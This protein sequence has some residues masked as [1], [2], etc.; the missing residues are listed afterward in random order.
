MIHNIMEL[1]S[2]PIVILWIAITIM[3]KAIKR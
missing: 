1:L 3:K 2:K